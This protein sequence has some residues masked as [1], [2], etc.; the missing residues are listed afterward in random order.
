MRRAPAAAQPASQ[1]QFGQPRATRE[2]L[3][4]ARFAVQHPEMLFALNEEKTAI[5]APISIQ[6]ISYN[7]IAAKPVEIPPISVAP[8]QI[9]SLNS[10]N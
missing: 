9:S 1:P 6:A 2:E 3:L 4:L 7:P 5:D 8:I 10:P